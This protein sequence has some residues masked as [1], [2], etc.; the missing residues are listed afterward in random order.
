[1]DS[2]R[3]LRAELCPSEPCLPGPAP[4]RW[5]RAGQCRPRS[6]PSTRISQDL[7]CSSPRSFLCKI[8]S[9]LFRRPMA[10]SSTLQHVYF[11]LEQRQSLI[12]TISK[13]DKWEK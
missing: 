12:E 3:C 9:Q 1:M 2:R 11:A 5:F 7:K 6:A 8:V 4:E 10:P 13:I